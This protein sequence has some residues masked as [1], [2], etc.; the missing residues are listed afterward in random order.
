[1][2]FFASTNRVVVETKVEEEIADPCHRHMSNAYVDPWD[3][4]NNFCFGVYAQK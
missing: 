3:M 2:E 4:L 1:M